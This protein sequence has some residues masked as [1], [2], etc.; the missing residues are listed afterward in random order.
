MQAAHTTNVEFI[1]ELMET[2]A[3]GSLMQPFVLEA[4]RIYA[5]MVIEDGPW[6]AETTMFISQ[7]AWKLCA[8]ECL[9]AINLRHTI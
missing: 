1:T 6:P 5:E 3:A 8:K 9:D 7:D 4:L 2:S